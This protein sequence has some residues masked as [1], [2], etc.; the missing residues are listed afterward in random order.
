MAILY[1]LHVEIWLKCGPPK[2]INREALK[3][4]DYWIPCQCKR[5]CGLEWNFVNLIGLHRGGDEAKCDVV[6]Y[7]ASGS[8]YQFW[9]RKYKVLKAMKEKW[10]IGRNIVPSS[11][12]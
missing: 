4:F 7:L 3:R 12:F 6:K 11:T 1:M 10:G 9:S 5:C 8:A 2:D